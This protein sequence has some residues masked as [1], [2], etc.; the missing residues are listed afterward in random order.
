MFDYNLLFMLFSCV[1]IGGV[2]ILPRALL[3]YVPGGEVWVGGLVGEFC[4]CGL[5]C[6][7]VGSAGLQGQL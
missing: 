1:C 5:C 6:S 3:D 7:P 2:F 4:V